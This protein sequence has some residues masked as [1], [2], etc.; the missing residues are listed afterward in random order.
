MCFY[1]FGDVL[2]ELDLGLGGKFILYLG[3]VLDDVQLKGIRW[4]VD[5][6]NL[7]KDVIKDK[8]HVI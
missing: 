8:S 3:Q 7:I 4:L 5:W 2:K 1:I 6:F